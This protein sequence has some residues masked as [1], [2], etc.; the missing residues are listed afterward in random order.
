MRGRG[1]IYLV[2]TVILLITA[3]AGVTAQSRVGEI[4]TIEGYAEIDAFGRDRFIKAREGD[5]LYESSKVRTDYDSWVTAEINGERYQI[6]PNS[7]T[8]I[9]T[10]VTDR[11][12]G[13]QGVLGR[14]LRNIMDSLAPPEEEVADFGGRASDAAQDDGFDSMFVTDVDADEE[15]AA[16]H[17]A[18]AAGD[19]REAAER[20]RRIEYPEDGTFELTEYYVG[21]THA[22]LGL[23]DVDAA[24]GAAFDYALAE[25]AAGTVT[26]LP[27]RLQL[28]A[29]ISAYYA[30]EDAIALEAT[31]QYIAELG[32]AE[33][34]PQA[35]AIRILLL[36]RT[37]RTE[38]QTL[39][40]E[41]RS[42]RPNLDWD[43]L[44]EG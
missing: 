16:G 31:E 8:R 18:L 13:G 33:A 32:V 17:E 40:R 24:M 12:R 4:V 15:F 44:L 27:T 30:G 35:V 41:A 29:A 42:S 10:Y 11:R 37:N 1:S 9:S 39:E 43:T 5:V 6:A 2:L 38:A 34:D 36:Q 23:G 7:T 22:L 21:L 19:Y 14:L 20:F 28:L 25:P 3:V 26:T